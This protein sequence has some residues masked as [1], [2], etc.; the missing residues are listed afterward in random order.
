MMNILK[1]NGKNGENMISSEIIIFIL[2][3]FGLALALSPAK[4]K[5]PRTFKEDLDRYLKIK[6]IK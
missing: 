2:L 3:L 4:R 1:K 5:K 6:G